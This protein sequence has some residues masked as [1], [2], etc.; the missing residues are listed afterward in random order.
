M[1]W[2]P[3]VTSLQI[4]D[5]IEALFSHED[6]GQCELKAAIEPSVMLLVLQFLPIADILRVSRYILHSHTH[7]LTYLLDY[8]LT[9]SLTHLLTYLLSYS[10]I[11]FVR[12]SKAMFCICNAEELWTYLLFHRNKLSNSFIYATNFGPLRMYQSHGSFSR[13]KSV[14]IFLFLYFQE[15]TRGNGY[16]KTRGRPI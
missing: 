1:K 11:S 8:S 2:K 15:K 10:L 5:F 7:L 12:T 3:S 16:G 4:L 14:F 13:A 9:H 6:E